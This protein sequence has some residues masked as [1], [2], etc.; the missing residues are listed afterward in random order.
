V[1]GS[2]EAKDAFDDQEDYEEIVEIGEDG[3]VY[4][5]GRAPR[6]SGQKPSILRDP[7]GEYKI[8]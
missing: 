5:P 8:V 4:K 6:V 3:N 7:Q 2:S 1:S